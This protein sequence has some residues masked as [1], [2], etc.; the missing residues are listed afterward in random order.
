ML[1]EQTC[2]RKPFEVPSQ[3]ISFSVVNGTTTAAAVV[4]VAVVVVGVVVVG[5]V[6]VA[7][8]VVVDMDL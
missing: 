6:V 2:A 3:P 1:G 7:V 4:V 8:V 5:V